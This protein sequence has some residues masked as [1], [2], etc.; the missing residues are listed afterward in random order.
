MK[1]LRERL[2][3][4]HKREK[5]EFMKV[6]IREIELK[7]L[8]GD[9]PHNLVIKHP[10]QFE[11]RAGLEIAVVYLEGLGPPRLWLEINVDETGGVLIAKMGETSLNYIIN[12]KGKIQKL[13]G[14]KR[15]APGFESHIS[16]ETY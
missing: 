14:V 13:F 5:S 16:C 2:D 6:L 1:T 8:M 11:R 9:N 3:K 4:A 12:L 7:V 15:D 10:C